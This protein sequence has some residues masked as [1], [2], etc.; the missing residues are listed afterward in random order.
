MLF[1]NYLDL[2]TRNVA[3]T[4]MRQRHALPSPARS[5]NRGSV[6]PGE[7]PAWTLKS[8]PAV[9]RVGKDCPA[10]NMPLESGILEDDLSTQP[11]IS[12]SSMAPSWTDVGHVLGNMLGGAL[13]IGGMFLLPFILRQLASFL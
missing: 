6:H 4:S 7:G 11:A 10:A 1:S 13:F 8:V 2:K 3:S 12:G 5:L 9:A